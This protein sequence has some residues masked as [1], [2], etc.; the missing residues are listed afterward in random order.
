MAKLKICLDA[1]HYGKYNRSSVVPAFY[2]S[3]FNWKYHLLLKKYLEEYD[4]DVVTTRGKQDED[5]DLYERGRRAK[6]CNLFYS[7]HANWAARESADYP[8]AYVPINGSADKI[9]M[10][11]AQCVARVMETREGAMIS[12]KKS[13]K[14]NWDWYGVLYGCTE[15]GVPGLILE[16]SFYSNPKSA[17]WLMDDENL[18]RMAWE[19]A[20]EIA[21]FYGV[22]K[23]DQQGE[24][25]VISGAYT[26][27]AYAENQLRLVRG[28]YP[29]ACII[30]ADGYYKVQIAAFRTASEANAKQAEVK[31]KG[32]GCYISIDTDVEVVAQTAS[33]QESTY[34]Q[35]QFVR[36]LQEAIG[37]AV[38]GIAGQETL[39]KT[40][41]LSAKVN[42]THKA[43]KPVQRRLYAM[44]Y[45]E[46]GDADGEA[47]TK[48]TAAVA[49]FQQEHGCY[50]SGELSEWG[51][52]W[53]KLL[54]IE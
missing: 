19:E 23:L 27:L 25:R 36:D 14:G 6:G 48:F 4:I 22:K 26:V 16:H 28:I 50:P 5:L 34:T 15:V 53:H 41:T 29:N 49:H 47:G 54:G 11:L 42:A 24:Y 39:R 1:G 43:V 32:I 7:V 51:K 31:G 10:K 45:T 30:R 52:T 44:G 37:A 46:V 35:K 40:P 12:K 18:D 13:E 8:V 20:A 38:D 9:G 33:V 2:E 21:A 3:D 17:Q